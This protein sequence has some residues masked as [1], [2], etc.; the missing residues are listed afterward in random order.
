M[1]MNASDLPISG[2]FILA[3]AAYV[4]LSLFLSLIHI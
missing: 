2:S 3:A 4:G 1:L